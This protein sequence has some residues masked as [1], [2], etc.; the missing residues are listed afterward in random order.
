MGPLV[1]V[2]RSQAA[3]TEYSTISGRTP[4][5]DVDQL[6]RTYLLARSGKMQ[7]GLLE[8]KK[9]DPRLPTILWA[10]EHSFA[11][12]GKGTAPSGLDS[13]TL[14]TLAAFLVLDGQLST[15][16]PS[17][18]VRAINVTALLKNANAPASVQEA[19]RALAALADARVALGWDTWGQ[20]VLTANAPAGNP[21]ALALGS[22]FNNLPMVTG[23]SDRLGRLISHKGLVDVVRV[24]KKDLTSLELLTP[25]PAADVDATTDDLPGVHF[26]ASALR[27]SDLVQRA[28]RAL[29]VAL[30]SA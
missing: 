2:G 17:G 5:N 21:E 29:A 4:V 20:T 30:A 1:D 14:E 11:G 6:A 23:V 8:L 13:K 12:W 22:R 9:D 27:L 10:L 18:A 15:P 3:P 16:L 26:V 24:I 25:N 19:V 28:L 7:E